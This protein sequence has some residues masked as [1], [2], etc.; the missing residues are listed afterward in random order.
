[1]L[2]VLEARGLTVSDEQRK[3]IEG[4]TDLQALDRLIR[5]AATVESTDELFED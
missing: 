2:A 5:S 3:R 1:V 4:T